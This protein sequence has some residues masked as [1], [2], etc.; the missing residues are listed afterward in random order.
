MGKFRI[1]VKAVVEYEGKYLAVER[2]YNDCIVEPYQWEFLDGEMEFGEAPEHAA[3]RIAAEYTGLH[4][5]VMDTLY[6]WEFT[7]GEVSTIGIA[8]ACKA[9][10]DEIILADELLNYKWISK[11]EFTGVITRNAVLRDMTRVG[12]IGA[13]DV[14]E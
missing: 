10:N 6:T 8:F 14:E 5:E 13:A 12:F 11:E 4:T 7:A 3:I 9:L 2:W 1:I